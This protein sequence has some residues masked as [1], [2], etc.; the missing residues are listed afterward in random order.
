MDTQQDRLVHYLDDAWALEKALVSMLEDMA[1]EVNDPEIRSLFEEHRATTHR[2]EEDLEARI[3]ALGK[4]PSKL[5][6]VANRV[7]A[8]LGDVIHSAHDDYDKTAQHLMEAFAAEHLE[9]AMYES[10][11]SYAEAIGDEETAKLARDHFEDEEEAADK[12]WQMIA[13][14]AARPARAEIRTG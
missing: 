11:A 12:V 10:L 9:M 8:K 4:E 5:K 14:V 3:R 2:H 7:I 13:P 1:D 6:G